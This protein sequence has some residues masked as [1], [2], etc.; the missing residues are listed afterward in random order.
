MPDESAD[1]FL[2]YWGLHCFRDPAAALAEARRVL[3]PNGRLVGSSF[4]KGND[5]LRQRLLV[6]PDT[7]DFGSVGTQSEVEAWLASAGFEPV[8]LRRSG[9]M[10]FFRA[11]LEG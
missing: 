11:A 5:T 4:V 9:P 2:S 6:R 8:E 10:L 1:L 3:R 7:G